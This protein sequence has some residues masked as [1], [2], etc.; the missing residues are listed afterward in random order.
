MKERSVDMGNKIELPLEIV[1]YDPAWLDMFDHK[2]KQL[3]SH[4]DCPF[5]KVEHVG[6]TAIPNAKAKPIIDMLGIVEDL[7][8]IE[9]VQSVLT[10]FNFCLH[11]IKEDDYYYFLKQDGDKYYS[12]TV[13]AKDNH[14]GI[15]GLVSFKEFLMSHPHAQIKYDFLKAV[16]QIEY[17][18]DID[19]YAKV[20]DEFV[21]EIKRKL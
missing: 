8:Q 16:A 15:K 10:E 2:Q 3:L 11:N 6:S 12:L 4:Q 9:Q 5:I 13:M 19:K 21:N 20:K 14:K 1:D 7:N 17:P 18:D